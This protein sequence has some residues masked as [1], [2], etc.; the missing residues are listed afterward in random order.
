MFSSLIVFVLLIFIFFLPVSPLGSLYLCFFFFCL[1]FLF[2][3]ACVSFVLTALSACQPTA[4]SP[5]VSAHVSASVHCVCLLP[6]STAYA[7]IFASCFCL[8]VSLYIYNFLFSSSVPTSLIQSSSSSPRLSLCFLSALQ[9]HSSLF[10]HCLSPACL[11][12]CGDAAFLMFLLLGTCPGSYGVVGGLSVRT[13]NGKMSR[14][15]A[16]SL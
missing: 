4:L 13:A 16:L 1:L 12:D 6:V 8:Y 2:F 7:A 3:T 14:I 5:S 15:K 10:C 11:S 9:L